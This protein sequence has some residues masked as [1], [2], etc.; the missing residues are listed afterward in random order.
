MHTPKIKICGMRDAENVKQILAFKPDFLGFIFYE[1]SKRFVS[2]SQMEQIRKLEFGETHAVGVF[3]N[4]DV[5]KIIDKAEKGYF[6]YVQLHG[7]ES[8]EVIHVLQD[9][10]LI[11]IK[12]FAIDD[13][14]DLNV[15]QT[16]SAADYFLFDTKGKLPGGN[17]VK[18]NWN[19]LKS[20]QIKKPFFL[21]GG[22]SLEDAKSIN[23]FQSAELYALD[24]NS[25]LEVE[26]G[27]KDVAKVQ[28]VLKF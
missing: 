23:Q 6:K 22:L 12:V 11:A 5:N 7:N 18:F 1:N 14:F 15:L 21:S 28:E 13:D 16:Y 25:K 4:E 8:P 19:V 27:L 20:N 17:G 24:F 10:G 2:D 9:A 3:V 26:P